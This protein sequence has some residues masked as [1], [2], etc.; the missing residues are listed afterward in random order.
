MPTSQSLFLFFPAVRA[1][2]SFNQMAAAGARMTFPP[3]YF[4]TA[5]RRRILDDR[6]RRFVKRNI[7]DDAPDDMDAVLASSGAQGGQ[8][9]SALERLAPLLTLV[10]A[11]GFWMAVVSWV[12]Y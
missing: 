12:F 1:Q 5:R 4:Q 9:A 11:S 8:N 7:I 2:H 10:V 6:I 3:M